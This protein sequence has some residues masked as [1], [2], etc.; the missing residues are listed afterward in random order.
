MPKTQTDA[1]RIVQA[2]SITNSPE[3]EIY[4]CKILAHFHPQGLRCPHCKTGVQHS[5]CFRT[6]QKSK[7]TVY[8]CRTCH[9]TYNL[10]SQTIFE[11]R[12]LRPSQVVQLIKA[13]VQG[14]STAAIARQVNVSR[15][16]ATEL[17][18]RLKTEADYLQLPLFVAH[19]DELK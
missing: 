2:L 19:Y 13:V 12:H 10:Y 15:T 14:H 1:L 18:Q 16:T 11:A 6:T 4:A 9:G 8:R 17:C 3:E 5:Y 7:L